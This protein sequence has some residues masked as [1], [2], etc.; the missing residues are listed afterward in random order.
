MDN[1]PDWARPMMVH[2]K[3][4]T[5]KMHT[6]YL[7]LNTKHNSL[8][9]EMHN[10]RLENEKEKAELS[11]NLEFMQGEVNDLRHEDEKL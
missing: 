7:A 2:L 11:T 3:N 8:T 4:S 6:S 1:A 10:I 9:I 5:K